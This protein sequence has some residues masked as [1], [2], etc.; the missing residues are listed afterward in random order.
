MLRF[1]TSTLLRTRH[2]VRLDTRASYIRG[3]WPEPLTQQ[4]LGDF[5]EDINYF[6]QP[7]K[8]NNIGLTK[9][10]DLKTEE[11]SLDNDNKKDDGQQRTNNRTGVWSLENDKVEPKPVD[12]VLSMLSHEAVVPMLDYDDV[13]VD[14]HQLT[15]LAF[16]YGIYRDLF[17]PDF[18][19]NREHINFTKEQA[20]RLDKLVP[21]YWITDQPFARVALK[22][23]EPKTLDYFEPIVGI[24]ARFVNNSELDSNAEGDDLLWAHTTYYGNIMPASEVLAKPSITLDWNLLGDN[25]NNQ[26][27]AVIRETDFNNWSPGDISAVNFDQEK[28]EKFYTVM[29]VNL[30]HIHE[31]AANLHWMAS[32]IRPTATNT[33]LKY[34]EVCEYLP[35]HGIN[36]FGYSRYVFIVFQHDSEIDINQSRIE[37]FSLESRKFDATSFMKKH[38]SLNMVPIGLSWFQT[39]WDLS[40]NK[41]FH[42]YLKLKAPVYEHV[43]TKSEPKSLVNEPYP[44]K[45][46]FNI[47]LD[48][49]RKKKDINEQVLLERLKSVD[50]TNYKD[51]YVP[52]RVPPTVF[53]E[54][55]R[56]PSWMANVLM[57]K[58]NKIGYWRGLRPASA[59]LPLDNNADL[60]YPIRPIPSSRKIPPEHPNQYTVGK[61]KPIKNL[62][63]SKPANEHQ[64]V[65]IQDDHEV[66][67]EKVK[68]VMKE[69][70]GK[71]K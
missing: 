30:D 14:A 39:T 41:I 53:E 62:P 15:N 54:E 31:N 66:H 26:Q 52:P 45:V 18:V 42:D 38:K 8:V 10:L 5:L 11:D 55:E 20:E 29:L 60:D 7:R 37:G 36:G 49:G 68:Q 4:T 63:L 69:F 46:P 56:I 12:E 24:S 32:N 43:Q 47:F 67:L 33:A 28:S 61:R 51:Q 50:P 1:A 65:F 44:G 25:S 17:S 6:D 48:Y 22:P 2:L 3:F 57:K 21:H 9:K 13:T 34:D 58:K 35:V 19:P 70:E 40:S 71:K 27:A 23:K 16:N 64:A 59:I